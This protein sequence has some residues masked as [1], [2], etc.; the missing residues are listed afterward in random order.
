MQLK[1]KIKEAGQGLIAKMRNMKFK[2][3]TLPDIDINPFDDD[4]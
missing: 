2:S 1:E 3:P 4:E